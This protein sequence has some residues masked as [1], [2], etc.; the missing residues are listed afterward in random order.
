[1]RL[2]Q[3]EGESGD[4]DEHDDGLKEHRRGSFHVCSR[5][6]RIDSGP[7]VSA[8]VRVFP[9]TVAVKPSMPF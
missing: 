6:L 3:Q 7:F 5:A 9:E 8:P 1:M 2:P 4:A